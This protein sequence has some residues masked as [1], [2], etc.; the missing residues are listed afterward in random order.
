MGVPIVY[1]P[2]LSENLQLILAQNRILVYRIPYDIK[3]CK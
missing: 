1:E 2:V 3:H